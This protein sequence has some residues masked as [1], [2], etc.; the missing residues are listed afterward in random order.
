MTSTRHEAAQSDLPPVAAPR[1][2]VNGAMP[3]QSPFTPGWIPVRPGAQDHENVPSRTGLRREY[4]DGRV[5][6][7]S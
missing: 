2:I 6:D 1:T 7:A 5:E 4:R 3:N